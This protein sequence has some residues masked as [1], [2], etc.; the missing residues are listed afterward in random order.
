M[1]N[2]N[3]DPVFHE[4]L[5]IDSRFV[6]SKVISSGNR[7]TILQA[8]DSALDDYPVTLKMFYLEDE[9]DEETRRTLRK[10][11]ISSRKLSHPGI[12]AVYDV[13]SYEG[14]YIYACTQDIH[15]ET[16]S[17]F[18][19]RNSNKTLPHHFS[20]SFLYQMAHI[21]KSAHN[22]NLIH[23]SL[24]LDNIMILVEDMEIK[25][26]HLINFGHYTVASNEHP[27]K[28]KNSF[29]LA[30]ELDYID[31]A[32]YRTDIYSLGVVVLT[33]LLGKPLNEPSYSKLSSKEFVDTLLGEVKS[34]Q[35]RLPKWFFDLI[36]KMCSQ[37]PEERFDDVEEIQSKI[38][39]NFHGNRVSQANKIVRVN[40][41]SILNP[42]RT[43]IH[44]KHDDSKSNFLIAFGV[45]IFVAT[46]VFWK[47]LAS[48]FQNS[49]SF[50]SNVAGTAIQQ[51]TEDQQK[52]LTAIINHKDSEVFT[53]LKSGTSPDFRDQNGTPP[54][55]L[56]SSLGYAD[57][58]YTLLSKHP[59]LINTKDQNGDTALDI[60]TK[61]KK[62]DLIALLSRFKA[63]LD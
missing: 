19:Q 13:G 49:E 12:E 60:A 22:V 46:L 17:S 29:Y 20:L 45:T 62:T 11:L 51:I 39:E 3:P 58:A 34:I 43:F 25:E 41:P 28:G 37:N 53:L 44:P 54:L 18:L 63:K 36:A 24:N 8:L 4:G 59:R 26:I 2:N 42:N 61:N 6:V 14:K 47:P 21:L 35:K 40:T 30:P 15:C 10:E 27:N 23:K 48:V 33:I 50:P 56:A 5:V 38:I 1:I 32:N 7:T 57:I 16:L 52:L 31:E 55:H 9:H